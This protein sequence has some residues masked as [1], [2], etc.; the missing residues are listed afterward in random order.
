MQLIYNIVIWCWKCAQ[1][2]F[3]LELTLKRN[4]KRK[5]IYDEK[6]CLENW[7]L[8]RT[9][10]TDN[11]LRNATR[12]TRYCTRWYYK[13]YV[14]QLKLLSFATYAPKYLL[15]DVYANIICKLT[16]FLTNY[17]KN[18]HLQITI[19]KI[20]IAIFIDRSHRLDIHHDDYF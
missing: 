11:V 17:Y 16:S 13:S 1:E 10:K 4:F 5:Q 9:N 12:A 20:I 7:W 18:T 19:I 14:K 3:I 6:I 15:C 2:L 8:I